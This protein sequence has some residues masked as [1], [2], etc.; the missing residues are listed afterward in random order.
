MM[1]Q[2]NTKIVGKNGIEVIVPLTDK[3]KEYDLLEKAKDFMDTMNKKVELIDQ[4]ENPTT[5]EYF[6][7]DLNN[8]GEEVMDKNDEMILVFDKEVFESIGLIDDM[9]EVDVL[10]PLDKEDYEYMIRL[11]NDLWETGGSVQRRGD[12]EEDMTYLQP[13]PYTV[14]KQGDKYFTYT[15][16]EGGG[17][18]RL[19]G[20]TSIGAGGHMDPIDNAWNFEHLLAVNNARELEEEL[21]I[22]DENGKEIDYHYDLAKE[23]VITGLMYNQKTEVDSVHIGILNIINIPET[24]TVEPKETDT[25]EGK[26]LTKKE[27]QELD[28]ENWTKS[29]L[30]VLQ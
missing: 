24:W 25:L 27:I 28:L 8:Q 19:H 3:N 14:I 29:A 22:L 1:K 18:S 11:L 4:G 17:E 9:L 12:M 5:F 13:I 30:S 15:R 16:L 21:F 23:S 26:F 7:N 20:K 10:A 6:L 2:E